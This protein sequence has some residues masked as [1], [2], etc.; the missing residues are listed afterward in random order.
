MCH[1]RSG[2]KAKLKRKIKADKKTYIRERVVAWQP[3]WKK[4]D[5]Y[6]ISLGHVVAEA[7]IRSVK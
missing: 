3:K 6:D 1:K 5:Y 2:K 7:K 4:K